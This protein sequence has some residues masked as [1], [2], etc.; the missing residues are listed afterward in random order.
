MTQG[1]NRISER[2]LLFYLIS[3]GRMQGLRED[4]EETG[5]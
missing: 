1:N 5:R 2:R 3:R 4:N